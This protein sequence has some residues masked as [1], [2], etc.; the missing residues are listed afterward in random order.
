M[1][2]E[3]KDTVRQMTG[4]PKV[5]HA[6]YQ[7]IRQARLAKHRANGNE[8]TTGELAVLLALHGAV[9]MPAQNGDAQGVDTE[10]AED[11]LPAREP[12]AVAVEE[13]ARPAKRA[14]RPRKAARSVEPLPEPEEVDA[15]DLPPESD[16][17]IEI[18]SGLE[19]AARMLAAQ[20][21]GP[22]NEH[23]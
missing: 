3:L 19:D 7:A 22:D 8:L 6:L 16:G 15:S 21:N 4:R 14:G 17:S 10:D 1:P 9:E 18:N 5:S 11:F 2:S 12:A 20:I 23:G 13:P